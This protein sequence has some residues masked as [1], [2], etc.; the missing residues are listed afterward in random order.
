MDV[1][2][3]G[4]V[5]LNIMLL[6]LNRLDACIRLVA[7]QGVLVGLQTPLVHGDPA[8][9]IWI[10]TVAVVVLK[11][12]VFPQLMYRALREARVE[13]ELQPYVGFSS[14]MLAGI[15]ALLGSLWLSARLPLPHVPH[16][17]L[18]LPVAL[19]TAMVGVFI[20]VSRRQA[21]TQMLGYVV[22]EN[23]IYGLGMSLVSEVPVLV[24]LSTLLDVF[25]GVL[26]MNIAIFHISR[27]FEH[28]DVDYLD[29][30]KG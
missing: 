14:S 5:L 8:V 10:I 13:N 12:I 18:A 29:A 4:T 6:G 20:I 1:L 17:T 21:L 27:E 23:G 2:L 9:R 11:G 30:L 25:V 24:E 16:S 3:I 19:F 26:V 28:N 7:I 22:M 15:L